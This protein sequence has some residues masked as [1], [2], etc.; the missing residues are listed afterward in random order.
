MI[1]QRVVDL[2]DGYTKGNVPVQI[3]AWDGS[4]AGPRDAPTVSL[5]SPMALRRVLW[6]PGELGAAQAY[7]TGEIDVDQDLATA[8]SHVR[9]S[10]SADQYRL[11]PNVVWQALRIGAAAKVLGRR[12]Q[13]PRTQIKVT[14]A[15][16][17]TERDRDVIHHHYDLSNQFYAQILDESMAYSSAYWSGLAPNATLAQAQR[18]KFAQ[19]ARKANI[20]PGMRVLDVGCGWGSFSLFAAQEFDIDM[21]SITISREQKAFIDARVAERNLQ[22]RVDVRLQDYRELEAAGDFDAV[23][24]VEMGE[25]VGEQNYPTYARML[26]DAVR[27][28]G[29]VVIQQMSRDAHHPGGGPFIESFIAPDMHMRP[30]AQTRRLL[31]AAGLVVENVEDMREDYVRT[32]EKWRANFK[33]NT[34]E[35]ARLVDDEVLRVWDLYLAGGMLAFAEN[36]MGVEQFTAVRP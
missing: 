14:G 32:V 19:L 29:N 8:L 7:V 12:P 3:A 10:W 25:H 24:S 34:E 20:T 16:H 9:S 2:L 22:G 33:E 4:V 15:L 21:V 11:R 27:P 6:S 13:P 1:A 17:S 18:N 26:H 30:V 31:E 28:G 23:V 35:L 5:R 36:R